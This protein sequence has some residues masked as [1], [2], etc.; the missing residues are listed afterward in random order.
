MKNFIKTVFASMLGCFIVLGLFFLLIFGAIAAMTMGSE[1][2]YNLKDNT[3][4]TLKLDGILKE[5]TE[6]ENPLR[7]MVF[8]K[9][10]TSI[11]LNDILSSIQKAKENDKIKGIYIRV[12]TFSASSASLKEIRDALLD[13]KKSGKFIISY[14]DIYTQGV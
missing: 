5:K 10:T 7:E 1:E 9:E 11:G 8:G 6:A 3:V 2:S 12:G 13:F 14:G 4:L